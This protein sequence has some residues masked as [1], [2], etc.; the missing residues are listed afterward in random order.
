MQTENTDGK[1][2]LKDADKKKKNETEEGG[3]NIADENG[4]EEKKLSDEDAKL[5]KD[6]SAE[7]GELAKEE[8]A[9]VRSDENATTSMDP[10]GEVQEEHDAAKAEDDKKEV[11]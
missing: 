2:D 1:E 8:M 5:V 10:S 3:A 7:H 6:A 11:S 4:T 9:A